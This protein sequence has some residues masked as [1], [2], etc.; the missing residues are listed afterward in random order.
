MRLWRTLLL[1]LFI[2]ATAAEGAVAKAIWLAPG[3]PS[4]KQKGTQENPFLVSSAADIQW[5]LDNLD[6]LDELVPTAN[7]LPGIYNAEEAINV[8]TR[9][10]IVGS[11]F[12]ETI[13]RKS[14]QG[15][16]ASGI[17]QNNNLG[18]GEQIEIRDLAVDCNR[19]TRLGIVLFGDNITVRNVHVYNHVNLRDEYGTWLE[20]FAILLSNRVDSFLRH[21]VNTSGALVENCLVTDFHGHN[22]GGICIAGG[23]DPTVAAGIVRK[24]R[25]I[26]SAS[27]TIPT[28][29]SDAR[30][31]VGATLTEGC[32]TENVTIGSYVEG[33]I[34]REL[35]QNNRFLNCASAGVMISLRVTASA[36]TIEVHNNEISLADGGY[37]IFAVN[38][39]KLNGTLTNLI[40]E[41]NRITR[42]ARKAPAEWV[43]I[44]NV[45]NF[46]LKNN[47]Y[48]ASAVGRVRGSRGY[49][50]EN[51]SADGGWVTKTARLKVAKESTTNQ[52]QA[53]K[54][55]PTNDSRAEKK[56]AE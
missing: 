12:S 3:K 45:P 11:G 18:G 32:T 37:G 34:G 24:C 42:R 28:G 25:V 31:G 16:D 41:G 8:G 9:I 20:S 23:E 51:R 47:I 6:R 19:R 40:A 54:T 13:F 33:G 38:N 49:I 14:E 4:R 56:G 52:L 53:I 1:L 55:V 29:Q 35:I 36:D 17:F 50:G 21:W 7:F 15:K 26:G 22:G 48:D 10:S 27:P 44:F 2:T 30:W 39:G 43:N 46:V 5:K